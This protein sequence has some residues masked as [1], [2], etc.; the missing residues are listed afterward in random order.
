MEDFKN[1]RPLLVVGYTKSIGGAA[2]TKVGQGKQI[3]RLRQGLLRLA[4]T[5]EPVWR[6]R[7]GGRSATLRPPFALEPTGKKLPLGGKFARYELS[8][9]DGTY[10]VAFPKKDAELLRHAFGPAGS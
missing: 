8:T 9:A 4:V 10:D 5:E 2:M 7:R 1:G 3:A 6:D